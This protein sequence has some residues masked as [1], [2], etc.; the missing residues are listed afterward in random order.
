[1]AGAAYE[2][3]A[4]SLLHRLAWDTPALIVAAAVAAWVIA[5][6]LSK[7]YDRRSGGDS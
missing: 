7:P 3:E 4:V 2:G 6:R 1:M 5:D